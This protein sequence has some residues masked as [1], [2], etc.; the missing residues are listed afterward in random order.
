MTETRIYPSL[1]MAFNPEAWNTPPVQELTNCQ[2]YALNTPIL[3][4]HP[5]G[6]QN[7]GNDFRRVKNDH[8]FSNPDKLRRLARYDG[9]L[10][11]SERQ[12]YPHHE[13]IVAL[14]GA[15]CELPLVDGRGIPYAHRVIHTFHY[16]RLDMDGNYSAKMGRKAIARA[17][18]ADTLAT[19]F[20]QELSQQGIENIKVK[21]A[22][23]FRVPET[24]LPFKVQP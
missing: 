2:G 9:L 21:H 24:G 1:R 7:G 3:F 11:V 20:A 16:Y 4:G 14:L 23:F 19:H 5:G 17:G 15:E 12:F 13:H 10:A 8:V 6:L 18:S 22:G